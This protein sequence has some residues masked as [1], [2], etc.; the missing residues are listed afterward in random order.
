MDTF[1]Q[2][3]LSR[4]LDDYRN[5]VAEAAETANAWHTMLEA[6]EIP[7]TAQVT[8]FQ[9]QGAVLHEKVKR[10]W[11]HYCRIGALFYRL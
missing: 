2:V 8:E 5:A 10:T 4:A 1:S 11:D 9:V 3:D 6:G 7:S